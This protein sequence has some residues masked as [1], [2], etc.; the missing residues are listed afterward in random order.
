[1]SWKRLW[2]RL[3]HPQ[4]VEADLDAEVRSYYQTVEERR[5]RQGET[6]DEAR[7]ATRLAFDDPGRVKERVRETRA[8]AFLETTLHDLRYA[9]R[10]LRK[11]PGFAVVAI[12]SL[13]LGLGA[14]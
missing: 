9:I 10:V 14:N 5:V 3:R 6:P 7:R 11:N 4:R 8:G 13:G 2:E 1:M 12:L